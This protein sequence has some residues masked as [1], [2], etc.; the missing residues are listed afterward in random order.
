MK[1][2]YYGK[3]NTLTTSPDALEII[4]EFEGFSAV[5]YTCPGGKETIGYGHVIKPD[6]NLAPLITEEIAT[7]L[8]WGDVKWAELAVNTYVKVPLSQNQFDALVSFVF[9]VGSGNFR[10]STLL[11]KLNELNY[12]DAANELLRWVFANKKRLN[13]LVKRREREKNL[14]LKEM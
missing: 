13:G 11:K 1:T 5:P 14:F 12:I 3:K 7:K 8:L 9:N 4:K 10:T 2:P 6:E